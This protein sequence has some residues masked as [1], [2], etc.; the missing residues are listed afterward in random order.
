[1]VTKI[2]FLLDTKTKTFFWRLTPLLMGALLFFGG[3][4]Y[5]RNLV[6]ALGG[7]VSVLLLAFA[8]LKK[9]KILLPKGFLAYNVFLIFFALSLT[10]SLDWQKSFVYLTGYATGSLLW[11]SFFNLK[12]KT[13]AYL[14]KIILILGILF[15]SFTLAYE[16]WEFA[17]FGRMGL[18]LVFPATFN[19]HHISDFWVVVLVFVIFKVLV[20]K[21]YIYSLF[22]IPGVYFL[23]IS[24]SRAAYVSL[25]VGASLI[26]YYQ[27]WLEKYK[28]YALP[29]FLFVVA[30]F[31]F[32][33]TQKTTLFSRI[34][35]LQA[36]VGIIKYP[37]GVGVG[38]FGS[39][40]AEFQ[41]GSLVGFS[42]LTH[43]IVLEVLVGMGIFGLTFVF[44]LYQVLKSLIEELGSKAVLPASAFLALLTNFLLDSTYFIPTMF[45]LLFIFLG[46]AQKERERN[47]KGMVFV[48]ITAFFLAIASFLISSGIIKPNLLV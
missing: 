26:F 41:S 31:L 10:W 29:F 5:E 21:K 18:T 36:L 43:N 30:L 2:K 42:F 3:L 35:F 14:G 32:A 34:Y 47:E 38:N 44:W 24:L 19:H 12:R 37:L 46:L 15:G 13:E 45:W 6:I 22:F 11:L 20:K 8:G 28:K 40:S 9:E 1:M 4:G 23:I 7:V 39:I 17:P 25:A 27:G 48:Y 33:G 16:L